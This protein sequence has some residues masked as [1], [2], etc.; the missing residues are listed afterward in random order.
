MPLQQKTEWT[1]QTGGVMRGSLITELNFQATVPYLL[2]MA[3]SIH[4]EEKLQRLAA[5]LYE[6]KETGE[7][8]EEY[9]SPAFLGKLLSAADCSDWLEAQLYKKTLFGDKRR[10]ELLPYLEKGMG[11]LCFDKKSGC[12]VIQLKVCSA[13]DGQICIYTH[14]LK[15]D[16]TGRLTDI[17]MRCGH[18]GIDE[19]L[20]GCINPDDKAYCQKLEAYFYRRALSV[21]DNRRYL[22]G[23]RLCGGTRCE[24][25]LAH[26]LRAKGRA[27]LWEIR[28]YLDK[29]PGSAEAKH[30]EAL[31]ALSLIKGGHIK[32]QNW[33]E[34]SF[35]EMIE[36]IRM[37]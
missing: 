2:C 37:N 20:K 7:R 6:G 8:R 4:P 16:M 34:A 28:Y 30:A 10:T 27:S 31:Q 33:N 22:E 13:A 12:H 26:Y 24:G 32:V 36:N 19:A 21:A 5:E 9:F 23:L 1:F 11:Y 14:P 15:Q 29:M 17:L 25:L 3:L 18:A 35:M